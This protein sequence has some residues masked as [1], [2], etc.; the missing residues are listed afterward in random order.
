LVKKTCSQIQFK[1]LHILFWL[2]FVYSLSNLFVEVSNTDRVIVLL[3][4]L[5]TSIAS[6]WF[7]RE[8]KKQPEDYLPYTKTIMKVFITLLVISFL[9]NVFGRV[10]LSKIIGVTAVYNLWLALGM[11][12]LVQIIMQSLFLQLEANKNSSSISSFI[13]FKMLQNKF[14]SIL[15]ILASVLWL[16]MLTQNLSIEDAVFTFIQNF[17]TQSR[18]LGGTNTQFT[19]QSI[20]IFIAVIWFSSVA[21]RIIS[22][23]YEVSGK[24]A[25]DIDVLKKKNRTSTL[26][27]KMAWCLL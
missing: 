20:I 3:L 5:A 14:R 9:C 11:Y 15:T 22:Y 18:S 26:L 10:T 7:Y 2:T 4:A 27:I 24:N 1:Y 21:A 19:F 12:Y 16:I 13:D 17:L 8:V 6:I 25:N 23:L